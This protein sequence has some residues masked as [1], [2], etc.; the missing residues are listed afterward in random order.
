MTAEGFEENR[1]AVVDAVDKI[2]AIIA[3]KKA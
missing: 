3:A 2:C 1:L